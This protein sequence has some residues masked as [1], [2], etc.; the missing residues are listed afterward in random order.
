MASA[1]RAITQRLAL[2]IALL[3]EVTKLQ[4]SRSLKEWCRCNRGVY[5][6]GPL[7]RLEGFVQ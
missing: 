3:L 1:W 4:L 5:N 2:T 7:V 6:N